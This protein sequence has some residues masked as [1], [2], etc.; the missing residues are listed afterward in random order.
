MIKKIGANS[1]NLKKTKI[2]ILPCEIYHNGKAKIDQYFRSKI[3]TVFES[4]PKFFK[5]N[6]KR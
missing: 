3:K 4:F 1:E 6:Q 5:F 2:S